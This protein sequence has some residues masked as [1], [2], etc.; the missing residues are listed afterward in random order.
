MEK[1]IIECRCI[2]EGNDYGFEYGCIKYIKRCE[3]QIHPCI[4]IDDEEFGT[5][6]DHD[7]AII[8]VVKLM[9]EGNFMP[10]LINKVLN[11][12]LDNVD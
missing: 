11:N 5:E 12:M 4:L 7:E 8:L 6:F 2:D 10:R 3:S 1:Y 9:K